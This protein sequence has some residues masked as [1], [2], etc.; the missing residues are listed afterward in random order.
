MITNRGHRFNKGHTHESIR[1]FFQPSM[2]DWAKGRGIDVRKGIIRNI[3]LRGD[4]D[5]NTL[6]RVRLDKNSLNQRL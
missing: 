5:T 4:I 1:T 2:Q 3:H 6:K